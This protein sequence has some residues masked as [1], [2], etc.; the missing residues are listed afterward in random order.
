MEKR[1]ISR[2]A[3]HT[4]VVSELREMIISDQ[5]TPGTHLQETKLCDLFNISR[6]P[7][8]EAFKVLEVEGLVTLKP[9]RGAH[10]T[11][12]SLQEIGELFEVVA[13]LERVAVELAIERLDAKKMR[14]LQRMHERMLGYYHDGCLRKCFQMDFDFHNKII[15]FTGNSI[16]VAQHANLMVRSQRG[17]YLA[18]H[19]QPRW[20]ESMQEHQQIM[21]AFDDRNA[22]LAA[23]I[24]KKHVLATG[25]V[26]Q[27]TLYPPLK[28]DVGMAKQAD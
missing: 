28:S 19:S 21:A 4:K 8:R 7:L 22:E 12:M 6:T 1:P 14:C 13:N 26:V 9:N 5:F 23:Q 27:T 18:L 10:V 15:E 11:K 3:L 25:V 17:R 20:D 24:M 2:N 16:L